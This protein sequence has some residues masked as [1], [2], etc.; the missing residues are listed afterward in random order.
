MVKINF[1]LPIEE[2]SEDIDQKFNMK[3]EIQFNSVWCNFITDLPIE[4]EAT[5]YKELSFYAE[6]YFFSPK[7]QNHQ[8]DGQY[9][10]YHAKTKTFRVGLLN[11]VINIL[12]KYGCE[13]NVIDKPSPEQFMQRSNTYELRPY[14]LLAA[15][16]CIEK[17]YGILKAPM[18]SGKTLMFIAIVDSERKFPVVFFC[19]SLDLAYQTVDRV[20]QFLPDVS[21]G[22]VGDGKVDIQDI[23]IVTVQSAFSAYSK[24]IK[25]KDFDKELPIEKKQKILIQI[26]LKRAKLVFYDECFPGKTLIHIDETTL[27]PIKKIYEDETIT[28]VLSY[29]EQTQTLE[30]K[31][32]IRRTKKDVSYKKMFSVSHYLNDRSKKYSVRCTDTHKFWT[33][34]RGYVEAKNL[35]CSDT[36]K[37]LTTGKLQK[38]MIRNIVY[39]DKCDKHFDNISSLNLHKNFKHTKDVVKY[40]EKIK[41]EVCK[42]L[43]NHD[44]SHMKLQYNGRG[45]SD[46]VSVYNIEVE[47]NHNYFANGFL[48]SNCHHSSS[49]TSKTILSKCTNTC[50][51]IGLTATPFA[52]KDEDMLVEEAIGDIIHTVTYSELIREGFLLRPTI[53]FYKLPKFDI[54]AA[55]PTVYK[56]AVVENKF[57]IGLIDLLVKSLNNNNKS[58]IIQTDTIYHA[59]VLHKAIKNSVVLTGKDKTD[60]RIDVIQKIREKKIMCCIST[61]FEEGIDLLSLD[62]TINAAGGLSSISTLQRMRSIT[63]AEGKTSCGIVDF[64]HDVKY[65]S[66]H[67]K[68]RLEIY[69]SEPEFKLIERDVSKCTLKELAKELE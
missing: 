45:F 23:T 57:F 33:K 55:Y 51:K 47:D 67:S 56:Q 10:L 41:L 5:I 8:W 14:Q 30:K 68:R 50:L 25:E 32:I 26:L 49:N 19:R 21:V 60:R 62:F 63:A 39:C 42:F 37:I 38:G 20:H 46:F 52:D 31:K 27:V 3:V 13:V 18:R 15:Q 59:N 6:N 29:N 36:L 65:I 66:K 34:N 9:H 2:V 64:Y 44:V 1:E 22:I 24:E 61:L 48:V 17:R 40:P 54:D 12:Q 11:R 28:H 7:F 16:D 58:V 35:T 4:L 43:Y 53:Y 69:K